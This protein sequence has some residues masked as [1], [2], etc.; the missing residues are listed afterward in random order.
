MKNEVQ[1]FSLEEAFNYSSMGLLH[2]RKKEVHSACTIIYF[3]QRIQ[4]D[5]LLVDLK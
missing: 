1:F 4:K 5:S 2:Y 3:I